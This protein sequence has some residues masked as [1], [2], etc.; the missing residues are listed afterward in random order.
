MNNSLLCRLFGHK[1]VVSKKYVTQIKEF[2]CTRCKT[3]FTE[4]GYG[5]P[6]KLTDRLKRYNEMFASYYQ[7]KQLS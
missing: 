7:E 1:I 5:H 2:E 4:D 3:Q 6:V